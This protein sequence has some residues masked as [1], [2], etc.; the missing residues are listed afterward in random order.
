MGHGDPA[1]RPSRVRYLVLA[2]ACSLAVLTYVQRQGYVAA[3]PYIGPELSFD[4]EH[5]GYLASIWLVAYGLFQVPAGLLGDR[6]G[7]RQLLTFLVVGWSLAVGSI[8]L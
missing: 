2:V 8:A 1:A 5:I 3:T 6:L 4:K 7:A